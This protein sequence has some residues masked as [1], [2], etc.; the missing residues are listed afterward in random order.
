MGFARKHGKSLKRGVIGFALGGPIGAGLAIAPKVFKETGRALKK[1]VG[2]LTGAADQVEAMNRNADAQIAAAQQAA[3]A[4]VA[5]LNASSQ[6]AADA[7][8]IAADRQR[9]EAAASDAA[10]TP[11]AVADVALDPA[12]TESVATTRRKTRAQFGKNY[13]S[14]VNI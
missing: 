4:Q 3:D 13:S 5:A 12:V 11:L 14:G 10:A 9:A 8:R 1:G 6:A 7:Q 2:S